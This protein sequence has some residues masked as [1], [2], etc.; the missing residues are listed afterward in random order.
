[1][2]ESPVPPALFFSL[3][4]ALATQYLLYLHENFIVF[5]NS[6]KSI[7]PQ[8]NGN[9]IGVALNLCS[10]PGGAVVKNPPANAGD[11]W[12]RKIRWIRRIF[13][14][15]SGGKES[16]CNAGDLG[17][18]PGSGRSP[19]EENGNPLQ[20]SC[21]GNH[22]DRGACWATVHGVTKSQTQLSD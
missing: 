10:F 7:P 16:V 18:V 6:M 1:M 9:F 21:L 13:P 15:G 5:S 17:S 14:G 8:K 12:V 22:M 11:A 4:I 2:S 19:G 20:Y 3:G